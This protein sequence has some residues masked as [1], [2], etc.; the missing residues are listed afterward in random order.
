LLGF[1]GALGSIAVDKV[2]GLG[3][4]FDV[5]EV[6]YVYGVTRPLDGGLGAK[7]HVRPPMGFAACVAGTN[8]VA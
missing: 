2:G 5:T 4:F 7:T 1:V 3:V 6:E 8:R